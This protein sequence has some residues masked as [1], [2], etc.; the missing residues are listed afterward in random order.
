MVTSVAGHLTDW[1][2]HRYDLSYTDAMMAWTRYDRFTYDVDDRA[3]R[4]INRGDRWIPGW[5]HA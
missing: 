2:G 4:T 3:Y 5:G 1:A